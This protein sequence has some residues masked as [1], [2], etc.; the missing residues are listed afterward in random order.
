MYNTF[1]VNFMSVKTV[2]K[3][4]IDTLPESKAYEIYDFVR[5]LKKQYQEDSLL[6]SAE[7][8]SEESLKKIWDN[9]EDSVYDNL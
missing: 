4:E 8:L 6:K 7:K 5:F 9:D 1:E 3:E 2:L